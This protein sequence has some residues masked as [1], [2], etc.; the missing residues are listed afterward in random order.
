M[1]DLSFPDIDSIYDPLLA[2]SPAPAPAAPAAPVVAPVV[3][4]APIVPDLGVRKPSPVSVPNVLSGNTQFQPIPEWTYRRFHVTD[5][6]YSKVGI[7]AMT[8]LLTFS[9]LSI[10]NPP[11]VQEANDNP[12]EISRPS[13]PVLYCIS[14]LIFVLMM[15]VPVSN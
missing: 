2:S 3:A 11:F 1:A 9:V 12:I 8:S 10:T 14:L 6:F 7:S 13:L 15:V 5:V 4:T